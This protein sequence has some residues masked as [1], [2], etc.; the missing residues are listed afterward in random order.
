MALLLIA[1]NSSLMVPAN[2]KDSE[3]GWAPGGVK[4]IVRQKDPETGN[5]VP[6]NAGTPESLFGFYYRPVCFDDETGDIDCLAGQPVECDAAPDGKYVWWYSGLKATP[7]ETWPRYGD[8][9]TCIYTSDPDEVAAELVG[10]VL[11]EFQTAPIDP[12][13][14]T[15]QPSPF[16]LVNMPTNLYAEAREQTFDMSLLGQSIRI[17]VRPTEYEWNYGDG[18]IYG[19]SSRPGDPLPD[20]LVGDATQT[21]HTYEEPGEYFVSVAIYFSGRY[22]INGGPMIPIDGRA[23][24]FPPTQTIS[25]WESESRSVADDCLANPAGFGC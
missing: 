4:G 15:L 3:G 2:A 14:F 16:S 25:V 22:S 21:S 1:I 24:A 10:L 6:V 11:T 17:Q 20:D 12:G 7:R 8:T 18:T 19:P 9:P 13:Q 23:L 5:I